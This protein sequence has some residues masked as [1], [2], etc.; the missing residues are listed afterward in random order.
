MD[1]SRCVHNKK[2][3]VDTKFCLL[4]LSFNHGKLCY[5]QGQYSATLRVLG[6]N[7]IQYDYLTS[8]DSGTELMVLL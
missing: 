5:L 3:R 6:N 7:Y 4:S 2:N 8:A 1:F